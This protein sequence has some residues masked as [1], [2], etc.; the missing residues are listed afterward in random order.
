V[1]RIYDIR[2]LIAVMKADALKLPAIAA[3]DVADSTEETRMPV[4]RAEAVDRII[5]VIEGTVLPDSWR[6]N[7]GAVGSVQELA[8]QLVV[9]QTMEGHRLLSDFLRR[10]RAGAGDGREAKP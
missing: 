9:V 1:P 4:T 7:G 5:Q 10:L 2:D 6:D 3:G 8:G